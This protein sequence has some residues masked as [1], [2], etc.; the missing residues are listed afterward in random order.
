MSN[1]RR[2]FLIGTGLLGTGLAVGVFRFYRPRDHLTAPP[3]LQAGAGEVVLTAWIK[4]GSDGR[5]TVM[6]PRQEMGQG[7]TTTLPMLVAEEMD[8]DP[9][10]VRFEQAPID[11]MYANATMMSEAA[12][13][14]SDDQSASARFGRWTEFKL[15]EA[16]GIQATGGSSSTLDAWGPM[17]QAGAAARALLLTAAAGQWQVPAE[18]LRIEKG[19]IRH[20][21]SG[22]AAGFGEFAAQAARLPVPKAVTVRDPSA[23]T[24]LGRA[25]KR[26]DIP[27]KVNGSAVFGID[28]H[29]PGLHYA[30]L[31]Q[32]PTPG[33][34][35]ASFDARAAHG[36]PGV[37]D[38]FPIEATSTSAAALVV[39]AQ[40]YWQARQALDAVTIQW[41]DGAGAGHDSDRQRER[42]RQS[43]GTG[44]A[45]AYD[46]GGD[47]HAALA[48]ASRQI[49]AEYFVPYLAHATMEPINATALIGADGGCEIWVGNQSPTL[50]RRMAAMAAG[51]DGDR[52]VV[53]TPYLGGGFGRRFEMDVVMQVVAIA[54][55]RPGTP[56]Q[57]IW[58]REEDM[59]HDAY[60]PMAMAAL[61]AGF[62]TNGRI[63]AWHQRVVGQSVAG[64][65]TERLA[66]A[67]ASDFLKD[68]T[69]VE[70]GFDLP[71]DLPNRLTEHGV[72]H[73][74]VPVGFWR[75]VGHSYTAFFAE[76]FIDECAQAA[77]RDPVDYRRSLLQHAPRHLRV[78][79]EVAKRS[80]WDQPAMPGTGRG[81]ALVES[82]GSI[83]AQV[84]EVELRDGQPRV[85][86]VVCAVD[87]GFAVDPGIVE[88]QMQG[89]IVFGLS[90][91]LYGNITFKDG[92]VQQSSFPDYEM[93]RLAQCP[94]IE[95]HIVDSGIENLGGIGEPGTPPVAPAVCNALF[96]LT[97]QRIRELPIRLAAAT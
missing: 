68:K 36:M 76:C 11:A 32:S 10:Q 23:F 94:K 39:V 63:V 27:A 71:Y 54:R 83:V 79:D 35:V 9:A 14:R 80:G 3:A 61:R 52:V 20:D 62:D 95:V 4:L 85:K 37:V 70:G 44:K 66:P 90:A 64:G 43:L 92:R 77:G 57:L 28:V 75:S 60:R 5:V 7:A 25:Q 53:H 55:R 21:A 13:F 50:V 42:Y 29:P 38:I 96:A 30:A 40:H 87:C 34:S 18:Q 73:E 17:R 74:P 91:A 45:R 81:V 72:Q 58:S 33:A 31:T 97:G 88:T 46:E 84:A 41:K 89:G 1:A 19:I 65:T 56:V 51:V 26:L 8:A 86:R 59:S 2:A 82:F 15:G 69:T 47:V 16:L 22:R 12:P 67:L 78:L 93:V 49:A 48:S 6:V 24:L